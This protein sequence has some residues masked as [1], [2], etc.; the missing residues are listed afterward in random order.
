MEKRL[1]KHP[2]SLFKYFAYSLY[3]KCRIPFILRKKKIKVLFILAELSSWKTEELYKEMLRNERFIPILGVTTSQESKGAKDALIEYISKRNYEYVDLDYGTNIID[4]ID[5]DFVFYY[6]PYPSS[7]SNGMFFTSHLK[8]IPCSINYGFPMDSNEHI[9]RTI[10]VCSYMYFVE[11][12][13]IYKIYKDYLG[14]MGQNLVYTG[15]PMQDLLL[16]DKTIFEDPWKDKSGKFRIIYAPHHSIQG[17]NGQGI[18]YATF[19]K[20]GEFMLSLAKRYQDRITIAFKPHPNLYNKL[21]NIWGEEKTSSYY[22]EWEKLDNTQLEQGDYMGLFKHSDAMIHD[23]CSFIAEYLY[24]DKPSL[25]LILDD[26]NKILNDIN[27]FGRKGLECHEYAYSE[28]DIV[29]F[30]NNSIKGSDVK[31]NLRISFVKEFLTPPNNQS[32]SKNIVKA[33]LKE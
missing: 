19:L 4:K 6:K 1:F 3:V 29:E 10:Y 17:T 8:S 22:S 2:T 26:I 30:I 31:R 18:E 12:P 32:A 16:K 24:M 25:F 27:E 5:A 11:N 21:V 9:Y 7:Y 33:L 13:I 15:V 23:S 28:S 20:Y 14:F